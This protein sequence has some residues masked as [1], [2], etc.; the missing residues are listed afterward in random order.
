MTTST[1]PVLPTREQIVRATQER[2]EVAEQSP[3]PVFLKAAR[4]FAWTVAAVVAATAALLALAFVLR[5][6][7]A[8]PDAGFTQWVE[9]SVD[10]SMNPFRGIF[11]DRPLSDS[12]VF[13]ASLLFAA[14]VYFAVALVV[15]LGV[16][17]LTRRLQRRERETADLRAAADRAVEAAVLAVGTA[18]VRPLRDDRTAPVGQAPDHDRL[19]R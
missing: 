12:S 2:A 9:R 11:P 10:R 16:R 1:I 5:L 14:V 8:N 13:D 15:D 3:Y 7:G 17:G 6:G 19:P 4:V 18:P